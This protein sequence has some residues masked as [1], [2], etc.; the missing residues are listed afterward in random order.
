MPE[1]I[2]PAIQEQLRE[3]REAVQAHIAR[4][5]RSGDLERLL[6]EVDAAL[7]RLSAGTFGLC[8]TCHDPIE[9]DRLGA[10][11]LVRFCLDHLTDAEQRALERDLELAAAVQRALLPA[12]HA[13]MNG[14]EIAYHYEPARI[15]SGDYCDYVAAA[16]GEVYFMLGDVSGKGLAAS[17]LMSHL[18]ATLRAL[19]PLGLPLDE[20]MARAS[21][22]F[23]ES[24]PAAHYA[25]LVCGR[26]S[27][28]GRIEICN[29]GHPPPLV[30]G[31][32]QI[33]RIDATGLPLGMFCDERFEISRLAP[34]PS[35][36]LFLYS[37]GVVEARNGAGGDYGEA[38]L[39]TTAAAARDAALQAL[40]QACASDVTSFRAGAPRHDDLAVMAI[41][42]N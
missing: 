35:Q 31:E 4:R 23:C 39:S 38:R 22:Q 29:A 33:E 16:G 10:D 32:G 26:A 11:P 34:A 13:R 7:G 14:W 25:T 21:R 42:R 28:G 3:R 1:L 30:I 24:A 12:P 6:H 8:E 19:I 9:P 37:D 36:T 20:L 27:T 41:R 2:D 15:V 5:G 40:V 18:H 17:M